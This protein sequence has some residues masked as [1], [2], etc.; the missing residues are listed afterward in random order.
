[1]AFKKWL[2]EKLANTKLGGFIAEIGVAVRRAEMRPVLQE[3]FGEDCLDDLPNDAE[4]MS[5]LD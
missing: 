4:A 5:R 3:I 2:I 1:M